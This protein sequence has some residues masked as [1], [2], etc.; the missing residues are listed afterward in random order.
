VLNPNFVEDFKTQILKFEA[1][2]K[3]KKKI[4]IYI[5]F[6]DYY[7]FVVRQ[8][9]FLERESE[10]CAYEERKREQYV[11]RERER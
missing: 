11:E 6:I 7:R 3:L 8:K 1:K 2:K 5:I 4:Y 10:K 9:I